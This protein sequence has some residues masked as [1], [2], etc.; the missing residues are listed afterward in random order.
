MKCF[1]LQFEWI[2]DHFRIFRFA[3]ALK[4][5]TTLCDVGFL[6]RSFESFCD[7]S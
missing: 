5:L 3:L 6:L 1:K 2:L 4:I 7:K